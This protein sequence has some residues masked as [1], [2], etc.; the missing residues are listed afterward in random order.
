MGAYPKAKDHEPII[1]TGIA[2]KSGY[3]RPVRVNSP[4][5]PPA[6]SVGRRGLTKGERAIGMAL[7]EGE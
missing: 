6:R 2:A 1:A 3:S 7:I 5:L 4:P